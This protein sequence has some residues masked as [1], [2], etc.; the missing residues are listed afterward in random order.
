MTPQIALQAYRFF[1]VDH[2][3]RVLWDRSVQCM[4]D[5]E[6]QAVARTMMGGEQTIEVWDV[7]RFVVRVGGCNGHPD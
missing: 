1:A 6:A 3:D 5:S 2:A 4:D 7:A